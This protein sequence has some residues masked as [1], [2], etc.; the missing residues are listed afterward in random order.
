MLKFAALQQIMHTLLSHFWCNNTHTHTA[1]SRLYRFCPRQPGWAG[2]RRNI[3]PLTPIVVI[4]HPLSAS[5]IYYDPWHPLCS[6]HTPDSLFSTIP[7]QVF[8]GLPLGL[9]PSTSYSK[10]FFTQSLSSFRNT[11]YII[12]TC[13]TVV[14]RLSSNPRERL[15]LDHIISVIVYSEKV[16]KKATKIIPALKKLSYNERLIICQIQTQHYRHIKEIW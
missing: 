8:F 9:A 12:T 2:T 4:N 13:F 10:H 6:I 1:V 5:S 16:Q 14:P 3:H 15:G 11:C 7:L